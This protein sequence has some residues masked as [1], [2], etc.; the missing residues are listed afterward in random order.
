M[1]ALRVAALLVTLALSPAHPR[2]AAV[3][4]VAYS[5]AGAWIDRYDLAKLEDPGLAVAEMAE[6]HVHTLYVETGSWKVPTGTDIVAPEKVAA[7]IEAAHAYGLYAVGWYLPGLTDPATDLQRVQ[8]ALDFRTPQGERFDSFALDI[9][10]TGVRSITARNRVVLSLSRRFR[11][12]AGPRYPLGAIVPD[13]LSTSSADGLWAH[14]P[15]ASLARSYDVFL[16]MAYSTF[17]RARGARAVHSYSA[18]NAR[19][20]RAA[21]HR[22]VHL[23]SGLPDRMTAAEQAAALTGASAGGAIGA[24]L[25]EYALYDDRTW[26]AL[27]AFRSR[28]PQGAGGAP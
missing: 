19:F 8:A 12:A 21:T 7:L 23:I 13:H 4:P 1:D 11:A 24:S 22:P 18:A 17:G 25:Y 5:G 20:V 10:A 2:A 26:A 6:H 14:F 27:N 15:Y 16:P 28:R 9:E 3:H